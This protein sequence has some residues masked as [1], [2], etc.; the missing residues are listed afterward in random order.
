MP[1][2]SGSDAALAAAVEATVVALSAKP[3][4]AVLAAAKASPMLFFGPKTQT[5]ATDRRPLAKAFA[6]TAELTS[7]I[8]ART[9]EIKAMALTL[10]ANVDEKAAAPF[11]LPI[12][13]CDLTDYP[14]GTWEM[15]LFY[16][17]GAA[18]MQLAPK[19]SPG[20]F[21]ELLALG[22]ISEAYMPEGTFA[23]VSVDDLVRIA[24]DHPNAKLSGYALVSENVALRKP[25]ALLSLVERLPASQDDLLREAFAALGD[26]NHVA[27][28]PFLLRFSEG[29]ASPTLR[30]RAF[31]AVTAMDTPEAWKLLAPKLASSLEDPWGPSGGGGLSA[32]LNATLALH[33]QTSTEVLASYFTPA[34]LKT[35]KGLSRAEAILF[36]RSGRDRT[37]A[38]FDADPRWLDVAAALL[39][40]P[41]GMTARGF[42]ATYDAKLV[43]AALKRVGY[44]P[45]AKTKP[46]LH[47]LPSSPRWLKRYEAGEHEA[48]WAEIVA[49]EDSARDPAIVK[50][51]TAVARAMMTRVK[52]NLEGILAVLAKRKYK[53]AAKTAKKALAPPDPKL[54]QQ[55]EALE[56]IVGAPLPLSLRAFWEV[57]GSIDLTEEDA[58]SSSEGLGAHDPL[59]IAPPKL[60]LSL[61]KD[62]ADE[63]KRL[64][65]ALRQPIRDLI[66]GLDPKTK[67]DEDAPND[68]PY[69]LTIEGSRA[70]AVLR[71]GDREMTFVSYLREAIPAGGFPGPAV[72]AGDEERDAS[73]SLAAV[74]K[75]RSAF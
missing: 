24:N 32:A 41:I 11:V 74:R 12:M 52:Q 17:V 58:A 25:A 56:K 63:E 36:A 68:A 46:R 66:V 1:K 51:A 5:D 47:L 7:A 70:D 55:I 37:A 42:L 23:K 69:T 61:V 14:F 54:A 67:A 60:V 65:A 4:K 13:R 19:L 16:T 72:D 57:V 18:L 8:E 20:V 22:R 27:A 39:G 64:P 29:D 28:I 31:D 9:P 10:L 35:K 34:A 73:V 6:S 43:T 3:A 44:T 48:V 33:P 38:K 49:L 53:L 40:G 26:A 50:E 62:R 71:Q 59:L 15:D 30:G 75:G 2:Q 21:V 45:P